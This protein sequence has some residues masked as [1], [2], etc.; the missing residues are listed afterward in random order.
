MTRLR[1]EHHS[2]SLYT[3][4]CSASHT[5]NVIFKFTDDTTVLG[6]N[7]KCD[8][9]AYRTE[10]SNLARWCSVDDLSLNIQNTKEVILDSIR[11]GYAHVPLEMNAECEDS[12]PSNRILGTIINA[13][14]S[15]F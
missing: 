2:I 5:S 3:L 9:K 14:L 15:R 1:S 8:E 12:T 4:D 7:L 13:D 6:L 11:H 10:I